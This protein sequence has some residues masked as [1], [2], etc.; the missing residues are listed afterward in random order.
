MPALL[1]PGPSR[2][3]VLRGLGTVALGLPWL[4]SFG[5]EQGELPPPSPLIVVRQGNGVVQDRGG[6]PDRYWP[7]VEGP[8]DAALLAAD[9]ADGGDADRAVS[10]LARYADRMLLVKGTAA[11]FGSSGCAHAGAGNQLLTA[12]RVSSDPAGARSLALGESI[13]S[14]VARHHPQNG[15][16]PL[17]LYTG[18]RSASIHEMLSYRG[19]LDLRAA[20]DDP[21]SAYLRMVG[22]A[23]VAEALEDRRRSVNDLVRDQLRA[24]LGRTDLSASDRT[25]LDLHL[26][27]VRAF[28]LMACRLSDE[29]EAAMEALHG[30]SGLDDNRVAVAE[31]HCDLIALACACDHVRA[32]TLQV[33][34]GNDPTEYTIDGVRYEPYHAIS[35]RFV[36]R[37]AAPP[38]GGLG[39]PI[40]DAVDKHHAIDRLHLQIFAH[41]LDQ[42]DAFGV[43]DQAVV[44]HANELG[45]GATHVALD[46]PWI[47]VGRGDGTLAPGRYVNAGQV[48][49]N[50]V[51]NT[52]I[53]ATGLRTAAGEPITTFGDPELTPGL[54][55]P[56]VG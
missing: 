24:L 21:W 7:R 41:L 22:G 23:D 14:Y 31:L 13:D 33:G 44:V 15:G 34:D 19:P 52:L 32:A 43:L 20:E 9:P 12:A 36:G 35:H 5:R 47:V 8:L 2:R 56:M 16:E 48:A 45:D 53:T 51:L 49:H 4:E 10:E 6:T 46:L 1:P 18:P 29:Q 25:R 40:V 30:G 3:R 55:A 26:T 54:C 42:L 17:T 39:T 37:D 28:E 38:G 11:P 27:S 50:G